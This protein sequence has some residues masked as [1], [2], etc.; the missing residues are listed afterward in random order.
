M[1]FRHDPPSGPSV[2]TLR[3]ERLPLG[4]WRIVDREG[5]VRCCVH[6]TQRQTGRHNVFF[7]QFRLT[8]GLR[9]HV[10][11]MQFYRRLPSK[12]TIAQRA[13]STKR[14]DKQ[15]ETTCFSMI[16]LMQK[17]KKCSFTL[18][19]SD[20]FFNKCNSTADFPHRA[21]GQENQYDS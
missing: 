2:M 6:S 7:F 14:N 21:F 17:H 13:N 12:T 18:T 11:N 8:H 4:G 1:P 3:H 16:N 20:G 9:S 15:D 19:G 10:Q 5:R